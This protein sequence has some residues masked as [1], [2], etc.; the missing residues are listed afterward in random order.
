M[1]IEHLSY[2]KLSEELKEK[3]ESESDCG[4]GREYAS[5]LVLYDAQGQ[6][7][8][9]YSD[10]ME[11]EDATFYRDLDWIEDAIL[12]AYQRGLDDAEK[13]RE[14]EMSHEQQL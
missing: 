9:M 1:R 4:C 11:P 2:S 5:Y 13:L 8:Q 7:V 6:F 12:D 3:A 14:R 10:A